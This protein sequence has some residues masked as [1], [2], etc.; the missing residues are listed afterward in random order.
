LK[1]EKFSE[2]LL[3]AFSEYPDETTKLLDIV[4]EVADSNSSIGTFKVRRFI[5][6]QDQRAHDR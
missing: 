3:K 4:H 6:V 5:Q 2:P 1:N